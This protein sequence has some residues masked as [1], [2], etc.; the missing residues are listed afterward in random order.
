MAVPSTP[1]E[2]R[3]A[4][5]HAVAEADR[6]FAEVMRILDEKG[7]LDNAIVIVLSDHGEALGWDNDSMLRNVGTG[8]EIWNSLWGH[9]TSV[10]SPHQYSVLLAMRAYGR[11]RLPGAAADYSWPVSLEDIRPTLQ[12]FATGEAPVGV[13]GLSLLPYLAGAAD[14]ADLK[15]RIRYT[16]TGFN[17]SLVLAGKYNESGL[18]H[19]GT[20]YYE[21]ASISGWAQLRR[22]R[23]PE[24]MAQKQRA[25]ISSEWLLAAIPDAADGSTRYWLADRRTPVPR[26]I[27]TRPDSSSEP[28]AARLWEAL[29]GRFRGELADLTHSSPL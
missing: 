27:T 24:L 16:E 15:K 6:Q 13:D 19:E 7:A 5:K 26:Q 22:D 10:M 4:Y 2:Y 3:P 9:G 28:E 23:L 25:A 14:P 29:Q 17:F 21:L 11:A 8:Q 18:I 12:Q 1:T 20:A